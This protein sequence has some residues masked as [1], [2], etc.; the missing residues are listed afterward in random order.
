MDYNRAY[1]ILA[2]LEK[3]LGLKFSAN[4]VYLN[5]I[6]GLHLDEP[7]TDLG[8]ALALISSLTDRVIPDD[9]IAIGELG[10]SGEVRGVANVEGRVREA[11]RL[12]FHRAVVPQHNVQS[13]EKIAGIE[14]LS[15]KNVYDI[16]KFLKPKAE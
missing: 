1:L 8:V 4:D 11:A 7:A 2:V 9:L 10:L 15:A 5:D 16:L 13:C 6:G 3:R 14:I 12:G